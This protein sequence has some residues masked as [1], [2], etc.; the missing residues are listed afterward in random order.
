MKLKK[1]I[2]AIDN[3]QIYPELNDYEVKGI[4]CDSREVKNNFLF[5]AIKGNS[6]DGHTFIE[7]AIAKGA[8]AVVLQSGQEEIFRIIDRTAKSGQKISFIAVQNTRAALAKLASQFYEHPASKIKVIGITGT[9]GK[10]TVSYL[11]EALL[12]DAGKEPAVLGT[13]NYRFKDEVIPAKNTT[14]GPLQLQ[15]LLDR[16]CCCGANY[17]VMEVSSHA[18]DQGRVEGIKFASAIFTNLTQDH[19]DYHLTME[20]YFQAKSRLFRNL[21]PD[22]CCIINNDDVY[23]RRLS[24]LVSARKITYAIEGVADLVASDIES[25]LLKTDF[26]LEMEGKKINFST[27][28]IGRHNIYN[29]LASVAWAVS[30]GLDISSV[31]STVEK[32]VPAPGR[33][34]S[35]AAKEDFLVFVDYAHTPDALDNAIKT[36][37]QLTKKKVIVVFGCGGERDRTKRPKMGKVVSELA[38]YAIITNDNPR[39]ESPQ[40]IIADIQ[41]GI[42]KGNYC[43]VFDRLEAI[44]KSLSLANPEDVI[45][46]AGKGHENYQVLKDGTVYFDDREAVRKCLKSKS[47]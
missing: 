44:K 36:L 40:Q 14:P 23:G 13:I 5:V 10:T 19:L 38:D 45:L 22:S 46:I 15:E 16:I 11:V 27:K 32:F 47:S 31:K 9:N 24:G 41:K 33:L 42:N 30:E 17:L 37:R 7:E 35:I 39:S 20:N 18:L 25:S 4:S 28:L 8:R 2:Q 26:L 29:I 3:Y 43:V 6:G 34:E 21:T 12:K 1:L